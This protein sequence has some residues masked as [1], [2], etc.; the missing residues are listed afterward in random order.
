M[1]MSVRL[2]DV[3]SHPVVGQHIL[4][5]VHPAPSRRGDGRC[6]PLNRCNRM[7]CAEGPQL[8]DYLEAYH[9]RLQNRCHPPTLHTACQGQSCGGCIAAPGANV[10]HSRN[11]P[12]R[13]SSCPVTLPARLCVATRTTVLLDG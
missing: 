10:P 7:V 2:P 13:A 9:V 5:L 1:V 4:W 6:D 12:P 8:P 3:R 11:V